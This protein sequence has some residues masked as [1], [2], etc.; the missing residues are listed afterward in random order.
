[1]PGQLSKPPL[2]EALLEIRW[3]LDKLAPDTFRDP[4]Y[5]L[6]I[7]RWYDRI[8]DQFRYAHKEHRPLGQ[9][10]HSHPIYHPE[11]SSAPP[12]PRNG[13]LQGRQQA[14]DRKTPVHSS[15]RCSRPRESSEQRPQRVG[16]QYDAIGKGS[17]RKCL[18]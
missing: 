8:R 2:V 15:A 11:L 1:M 16:T 14:G 3:K 18:T 13:L 17:D 12:N 9:A 4:M 7:G 5:R 6:L 10:R